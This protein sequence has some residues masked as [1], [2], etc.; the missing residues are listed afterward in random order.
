MTIRDFARKHRTTAQEHGYLNA[1]KSAMGETLNMTILPFYMSYKEW[2]LQRRVPQ[3]QD[4][5]TELWDQ[6]EY[7]LL[8]FDTGRYD[9]L[10]PILTDLFNG[11]VQ[12]V[13]SA[14][15]DTF[16]WIGP[17]WGQRNHPETTYISGMV[18]VIEDIAEIQDGQFQS[19]YGGYNPGEHIGDIHSV[20]KDKWDATLSTVTPETLVDYAE[21]YLDRDK[22][23]VHFNQPHSPYCGVPK[24]L[25]HSNTP[26]AMPNQGNPNDE[27]I[28][29]A[30][31]AGTLSDTE[32]RVA[33]MGNAL[34]A[35]QA[36]T[37]LVEHRENVIITADHGEALGEYGMY[38]HH[39]TPHPKRRSVPWMEVDGIAEDLQEGRTVESNV[40]SKLEALGY[41]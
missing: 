28:W 38:A 31:R 23:V 11:D 14:A 22:L 9:Y 40:A 3:Q 19:M 13:Y 41:R 36:V 20:W 16:E 25:G 33:Y 32:L 39:R 12:E 5:L 24:L 15:R 37:A 17:T 18:P 29:R 27:P 35:L 10:E 21:D 26:S 7:T 6:D 1:S 34:R 8:V 2:Q 30:V 4:Y